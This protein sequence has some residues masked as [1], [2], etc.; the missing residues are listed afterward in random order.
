MNT[1]HVKRGS[2]GPVRSVKNLGWLRRHWKDVSRFEVTRDP[3]GYG[4]ALL[5]AHLR[6]G[7][8]YRTPFADASV[9][10]NFLDRPVFRGVAVKVTL[11]AA[12]CD[13]K[14]GDPAYRQLVGR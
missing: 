7:G 14:V 10:I 3:T 11:P 5:T 9:L 12:F 6:D 8:F 2:D 1:A 13:G 4:A